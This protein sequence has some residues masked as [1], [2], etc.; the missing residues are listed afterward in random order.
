MTVDKCT[1]EELACVRDL[2]SH[3]AGLRGSDNDVLDLKWLV[4]A[5]GHGGLALDGLRAMR[6]IRLVCIDFPRDLF[7][8]LY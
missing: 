1:R 5:V 2:D 7:L 6:S 4:W 8:G 3:F